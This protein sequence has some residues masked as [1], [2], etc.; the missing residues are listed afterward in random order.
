MFSS[1][2]KTVNCR[3]IYNVR[4][5]LRMRL[6]YSCGIKDLEVVWG[7]STDVFIVDFI[8]YVPI[9]NLSVMSGRVFL[10]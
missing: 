6:F 4:E 5:R 10:G 9:N 1:S 7:V 2:Q 8:L 3:T